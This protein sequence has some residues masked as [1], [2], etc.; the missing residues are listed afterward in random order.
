MTE[1]GSADCAITVGRN[2]AGRISIVMVL[3]VRSSVVA[4]AGDGTIA[5]AG[6]KNGRMAIERNRTRVDRFVLMSSAS[7]LLLSPPL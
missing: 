1:T 2:G 3:A 4:P 6:A 7:D 5:A